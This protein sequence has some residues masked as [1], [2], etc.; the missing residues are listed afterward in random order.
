MDSSTGK[1]YFSIGFCLQDSVPTPILEGDL[2]FQG[3]SLYACLDG[4]FTLIFHVVPRAV[5]IWDL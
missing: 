5:L 4:F 3:V 1:S 2:S